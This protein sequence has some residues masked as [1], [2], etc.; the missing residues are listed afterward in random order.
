MKCIK[1]VIILGVASTL[2]ASS[3]LGVSAASIKDIFDAKYYSEKYA[4]LK[5]A[6]GDDEE[7]LYEHYLTYGLKEGRS[8]SALFDVD[9]YR[10]KYAD[11]E[12]AFGDDWQAYAEHYLTYGLNE[13][14]DGGGEFDAA[15]YANRYADLKTAFGYDITALYKHYQEYGISENRNCL[16]QDEVEKLEAINAASKVNTTTKED[17]EDTM[18][19]D[20][21]GTYDEKVMLSNGGWQIKKYVDNVLVKITI[22]SSEGVLTSYSE[23]EYDEMGNKEK[24]SNYDAENVLLNYSKWEY[25]ETGLVSKLMN[26][27]SDGSIME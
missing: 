8:A 24:V 13:G 1:K 20:V 14:R 17:N 6:F 5:A 22:Y 15:S 16:S 27:N 9:E 23:Y 19:E 10:A 4:D 11:L 25:Y 18:D 26:Y 21:S 2:Y 12:T 7:A 3:V